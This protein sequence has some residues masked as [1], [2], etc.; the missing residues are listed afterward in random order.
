MAAETWSAKCNVLTKQL[1]FLLVGLRF[2]SK[3]P[4]Q[5]LV[6]DWFSI[7]E[8]QIGL[9]GSRLSCGL[10]NDEPR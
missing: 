10:E 2:D 8:D 9:S 6:A 4:D 1:F 7:C 5:S 3:K